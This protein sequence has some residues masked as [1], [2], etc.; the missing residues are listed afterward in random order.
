MPHFALQKSENATEDSIEIVNSKQVS[1]D[2]L[3]VVLEERDDISIVDSKKSQGRPS[4]ASKNS[5]P[6]A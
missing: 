6:E 1:N 4:I 3:E 5:G 2:Q